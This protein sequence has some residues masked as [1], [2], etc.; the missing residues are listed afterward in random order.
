MY[1]N[2]TLERN[3][4]HFTRPTLNLNFL[5][6]LTVILQT[7]AFLCYSEKCHGFFLKTPYKE[8]FDDLEYLNQSKLKFSIPEQNN[9]VIESTFQFKFQ[10][11]LKSSIVFINNFA[12]R[13]YILL[14]HKG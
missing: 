12:P 6:N 13:F 11:S 1:Y 8:L 3:T 9:G 14:V 7:L 2:N 5:S 10:V 4:F